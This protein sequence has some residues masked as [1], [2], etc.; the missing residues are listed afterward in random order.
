MTLA[1]RCSYLDMPN[2]SMTLKRPA[3]SQSK[4]KPSAD[5]M[6]TATPLKRTKRFNPEDIANSAEKTSKTSGGPVDL[7]RPP[8]VLSDGTK[9]AVVQREYDAVL[10]WDKS[11]AM[12]CR[13]NQKVA[14]WVAVMCDCIRNKDKGKWWRKGK[15][16][17]KQAR[18]NRVFFCIPIGLLSLC[19]LPRPPPWGGR[20]S[21][22][23]DRRPMEMQKNMIPGAED[24]ALFGGEREVRQW[25]LDR[26]SPE[27]MVLAT[28]RGRA[29]VHRRVQ[30]GGRISVRSITKVWT[31]LLARFNTLTFKGQGYN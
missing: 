2:T 25:V 8:S 15:E 6:A 4:P 28:G 9:F 17:R 13:E 1:C 27:E 7:G 29:A 24:G 3:A 20:S 5:D 21:K 26:M 10:E 23:T 12:L 31:L 18:W 19:L 14:E 30:N 11:M 22:R 16:V